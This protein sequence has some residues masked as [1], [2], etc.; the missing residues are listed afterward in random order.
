MYVEKVLCRLTEQI[1]FFFFVCERRIIKLFWWFPHWLVDNGDVHHLFSSDF[2][3]SFANS[4]SYCCLLQLKISVSSFSYL[5]SCEYA[6]TISFPVSSFIFRLMS[7]NTQ[8]KAGVLHSRKRLPIPPV[9][10]FFPNLWGG[11]VNNSPEIPWLI[12]IHAVY[13]S[14]L[15]YVLNESKHT[16]G[17]PQNVKI[18]QN[19]GGIGSLRRECRTA[20]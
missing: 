8:C 18:T 7:I 3:L 2:I 9:T 14:A 5:K 19:M 1:F 11:G 6:M 17:I 15:P 13:T 12:Q 4:H 20:S 16:A 10:V